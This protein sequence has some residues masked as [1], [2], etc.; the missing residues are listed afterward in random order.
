MAE[1]KTIFLHITDGS[2][3]RLCKA[4][5]EFWS[6][7]AFKIPRTELKSCDKNEEWSKLLHAPGIYFMFGNEDESDNQDKAGR[8]FVYI[9]QGEEDVLTRVRQKHDFEKK[10]RHYWHEV[11]ILVSDRSFLNG[12]TKYLEKRF[13][14]IAKEVDRFDLINTQQASITKVDNGLEVFIKDARL[15]L[16]HLGYNVL[17][18]L[19]SSTRIAE[20]DYLYLSKKDWKGKKATGVRKEDGFWVLKGSY[21]NSEEAD[22]L[23]PGYKSLRTEYKSLIDKNNILTKDILFSRPS[24]ASSFV[25]GRNSNGLKEWKNKDGVSLN[26]LDSDS[27]SSQK[28]SS[29]KTGAKK[30]SK[31]E[32][33][34]NFIP[35]GVE[36]LLLSGKAFSAAGYMLDD[37]Q[38]VVLKDSTMNPNTRK[39]SDN[40]IVK[41]RNELI[42]TG[43]VKNYSFTENHTFLSP[44][45]AAAVIVG[46]NSNGW[47]LWKN[48]KG[49]SLK[50]IKN[51]S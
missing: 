21:I 37:K 24:A 16:F 22:Y 45:M 29:K 6:G 13:I 31:R 19:P 41:L 12:K 35:H 11:V 5:L 38:F 3:S 32:K 26:C 15:V 8:S 27:S 36:M 44:S 40:G 42:E 4:E 50:E 34:D 51:R 2:E 7:L 25:Y 48:S 30:S 9:G 43:V 1:E 28:T 17:E 18:P 46:G 47:D 23:S 14:Q 33:K 49:R 10:E 39:S 20:E